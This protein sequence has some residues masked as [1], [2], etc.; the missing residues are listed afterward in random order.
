LDKGKKYIAKIHTDDDK[1]QT[2][3]KVAVTEKVVNQKDVLKFR[4]KAS[5]GIAIQF[6]FIK[7]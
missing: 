4:L 5:G 3:T 1:A 7:K 2:R 6:K